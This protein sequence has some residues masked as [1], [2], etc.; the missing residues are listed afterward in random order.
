[1]ST[2]TEGFYD[3]LSEDKNMNRNDDEDEESDKD[4]EAPGPTK[5][6][7]VLK[8]INGLPALKTLHEIVCADDKEGGG[9][10]SNSSSS[11]DGSLFMEY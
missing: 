6:D 8:E 1:M 7:G 11:Y 9:N 2:M 4:L 3:P 5:G 10:N